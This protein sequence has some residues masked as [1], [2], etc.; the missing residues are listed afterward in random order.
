M[1]GA[2]NKVLPIFKSFDIVL[3]T[4]STAFVLWIV[5][6]IFVLFREHDFL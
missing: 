3:Y 5:I 1:L 4:I 2:E 6:N